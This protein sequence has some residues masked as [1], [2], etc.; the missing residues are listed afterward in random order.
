MASADAA[1]FFNLARIFSL[2]GI[3]TYS[4]SNSLSVSTPSVLLGRSMTWPI[5]ASTV[6][7]LPRYFSIVFALVGDSTITKPLDNGSSFSWTTFS[8][9]STNVKCATSYGEKCREPRA[10]SGEQMHQNIPHCSLATDRLFQP[11]RS[12]FT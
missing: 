10:V 9:A 8:E 5:E 6:K 4:G 7:P 1:S 12:H 11:R 3:T 2:P